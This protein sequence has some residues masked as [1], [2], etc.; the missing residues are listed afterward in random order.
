VLLDKDGPDAESRQFQG[1]TEAHRAA[2][3]N[4]Y[5]VVGHSST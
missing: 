1:G 3:D 5:P 2:S 4:D